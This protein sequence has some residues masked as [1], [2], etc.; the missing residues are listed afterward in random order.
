MSI[1]LTSSINNPLFSHLFP[2]QLCQILIDPRRVAPMLLS[3]Q[4]IT[5]FGIRH[6]GGQINE[7]LSKWFFIK[8]NPWIV[9]LVIKSSLHIPDAEKCLDHQLT[10]V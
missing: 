1:A 3:H 6:G 7:L 8:E 4:T 5:D 9:K 2:L 10:H